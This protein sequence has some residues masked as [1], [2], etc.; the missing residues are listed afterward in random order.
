[1]Y[2]K[3]IRGCVLERTCFACPEQYDVYLDG[4]QIGYLRLR[5]GCFYATYPDVGG[6]IVYEDNPEGDGI[7]FD[8][9]R[10]FYLDRAIEE[11]LKEHAYNK[12]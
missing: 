5:H 1:M 2:D 4:K 7:F 11:L 9:E 3:E 12:V 6:K 10:G 8:N